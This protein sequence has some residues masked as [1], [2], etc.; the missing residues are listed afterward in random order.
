MKKYEFT[1]E[2]YEIYCQDYFL[3][4]ES[5]V[6]YN[7]F[8]DSVERGELVKC[9]NCEKWVDLDWT[10]EYE[11]DFVCEECK[12]DGFELWKNIIGA[13]SVI[14]AYQKNKRIVASVIEYL[15]GNKVSVHIMTY[16]IKIFVKR[17]RFALLTIDCGTQLMQNIVS[18]LNS[19]TSFIKVISVIINKE[20]ISY[21]TIKRKTNYTKQP[22][23]E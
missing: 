22:K 1:R 18:Q 2:E 17:K 14:R 6:N 15:F 11:S 4:A 10:Y 3:N 21:V 16:K 8:R 12:I 23:A 5:E 7:H 20:E 19:N 13:A 9:V